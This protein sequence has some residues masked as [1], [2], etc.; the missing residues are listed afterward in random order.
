MQNKTWL[1]ALLMSTLCAT[2]AW[3]Q[4]G[5]DCSNAQVITG[6]G[7]HTFDQT[8]ATFSGQNTSC[9]TG[10]VTGPDVWFSWTAGQDADYLVSSCGSSS[11]TVIAVYTDCLGTE[12]AC[13]DDDCALQSTATFTATQGDTYLIQ[14]AAWQNSTPGVGS[15]TIV[16]DLPIVN[17]NNGHSYRLV[18][19]HVDW[20]TAKAEAEAAM[21]NGQPGHL[22]TISDQAEADWLVATFPGQRPWIGLFQDVNDPNYSEP[23]GGWVWVTGEPVSYTNWAANEPN[24]ISGSGG[25]EDYA[26]LFGST[27]W[28]DAE[29]NHLN[30]SSY[31][32]EWDM[33]GGLGTPFCDPMDINSTGLP[34]RLTATGSMAAASGVHL[35]AD[36]G[37]PTQFGYFLI[38]TGASDPGIVISNGRLCLS[39]TGGNVFG[40]YNATGTLNSVSQFDAAGDLQNFVGTSSTGYGYDVPLTIPISGSPQI[41]AGETWHFQLW[42]REAAGASNFSNGLSITF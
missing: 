25:P 10:G 26:E 15:I 18:D 38:G 17:P 35:D 16:P 27:E 11:D 4:G 39:V 31:I 29:L 14:V 6:N 3:A 1:S 12:I 23:G 41:M 19:G 5:D 33:G 13:N 42:H 21:L 7:P 24:N 2:P 22:V 8:A 40:R 32:I 9:A 37:P 34:T 20:L 28:N 30:T 36:Q